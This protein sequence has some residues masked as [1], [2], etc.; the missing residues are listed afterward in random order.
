MGLRRL[1]QRTQWLK[2]ENDQG[3]TGTAFEMNPLKSL[4][5]TVRMSA[6]F[7]DRGTWASGR[8]AS[9]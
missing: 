2:I 7:V 4:K 8:G 9:F 1:E 5:Q 3:S 6:L